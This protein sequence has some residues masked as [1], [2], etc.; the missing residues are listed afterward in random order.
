[1]ELTPAALKYIN[2]L[3]G[4]PYSWWKEGDALTSAAPFWVDTTLPPPASLVHAAGCNCAGFLNLICRI[5]EIPIPG[6]ND[7]TLEDIKTLGGT[8]GWFESLQIQGKLVP[9]Q[10]FPTLLEIPS[11]SVLIRNFETEMEQGH[12]AIVIE[13]GQ[14]AHSWSERG[15]CIEPISLSHAWNENGFYTHVWPPSNV[16][17]HQ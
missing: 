10:T 11:G 13:P 4:T 7:T 1:M 3:I 17:T 14:I 9:I 12:V 8:Y 2:D 16:R 6:S 5:L 15:I